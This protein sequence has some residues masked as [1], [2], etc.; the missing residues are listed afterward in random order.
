MHTYEQP[1]PSL[2]HTCARLHAPGD[3]SQLPL[4]PKTSDN[5]PVCPSLPAFC[6]GRGGPDPGCTVKEVDCQGEEEAVA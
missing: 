5:M 1:V 3:L 6:P 4:C 2:C